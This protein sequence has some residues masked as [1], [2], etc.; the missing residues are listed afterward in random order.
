MI[1]FGAGARGPALWRQPGSQ[2]MLAE[3]GSELFVL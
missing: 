2:Q 3:P 1:C